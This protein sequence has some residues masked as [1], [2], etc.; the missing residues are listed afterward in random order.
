MTEWPRRKTS[1]R[2]I[3]RSATDD[4]G[5]CSFDLLWWSED[6]RKRAQCFFA[7]PEETR[8]RLLRTIRERKT[9]KQ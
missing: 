9:G 2:L 8:R 3:R 6:G 1:V 4:L 5:R 7:K